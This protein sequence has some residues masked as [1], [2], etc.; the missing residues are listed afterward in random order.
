MRVHLRRAKDPKSSWNVLQN[1]ACQTGC[2][3][4]ECSLSLG[5]Q[6]LENNETR[7]EVTPCSSWAA[8][9]PENVPAGK[10]SLGGSE[11]AKV[12]YFENREQR[13]SQSFQL[14]YY[15]PK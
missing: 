11:E 14:E 1:F 15:L 9:E 6:T 5:S 12:L 13:F 4:D 10:T 7:I 8:A 3:P 2:F